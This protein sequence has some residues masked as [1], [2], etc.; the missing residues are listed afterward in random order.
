MS[1]ARGALRPKERKARSSV[2]ES[3]KQKITPKALYTPM[4]A[5]LLIGARLIEPKPMA[6]VMAVIM[7]GVPTR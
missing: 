2:S 4:W 1:A 5:M 3:T 6:V 7:Q